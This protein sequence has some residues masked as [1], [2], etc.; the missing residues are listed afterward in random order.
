MVQRY[1]L[2]S[3]IQTKQAINKHFQ[4]KISVFSIHFQ[5]KNSQISLHFQTKNTK[6]RSISK[7]QTIYISIDKDVLRKQDAIADWSNGN[8]TLMQMILT[9]NQNI[10]Y[11]T[12]LIGIIYDKITKNFRLSII[13]TVPLH[14]NF[15]LNKNNDGNKKRNCSR[16]EALWIS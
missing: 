6:S 16:K 10:V 11:E 4:T 5:T 1:N 7:V 13:K 8:M 15:K 12:R 9:E 2:F 14:Q 3:R